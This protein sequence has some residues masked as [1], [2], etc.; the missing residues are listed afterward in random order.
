MGLI[1][2]PNSTITKDVKVVLLLSKMCD[3]K[4]M[5]RGNAWSETGATHYHAKLGLPYKGSATKGLVFC[6]WI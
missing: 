2:G 6:N 5:S 3:I 4:S 1:L